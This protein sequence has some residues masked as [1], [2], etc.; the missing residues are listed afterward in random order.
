MKASVEI[1]LYPLNEEYIPAID[2]FLLRLHNHQD[3]AV[4]VNAMST[5]ITGDYSRIMDVLKEEIGESLKEDGQQ[6]FVMKVLSGDVYA[7]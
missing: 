2:R 7:S 1:S 6:V 4:R 3:L 5:Q